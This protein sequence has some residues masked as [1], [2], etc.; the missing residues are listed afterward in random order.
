MLTQTKSLTWLVELASES[1]AKLL[2]NP[3][4]NSLSRASSIEELGWIHQLYF[5]SS[6]FTAATAIRYGKCDNPLFRNAFARHAAEEVEHPEQLANWMREYGLISAGETATSVKPNLPTLAL[7]AYFVRS[8]IREPLAHQII[9]L[10]LMT[11]SIAV[12]FYNRVN[13]K[14]A[15]LGLT[16]KGYWLVHQEADTEHQLLGL[17]LIPQ[18]SFDSALGKDY[19]RTIWE[20]T[21]LWQQV[22]YSWHELILISNQPYSLN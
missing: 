21:S 13:P 11:E 7:G 1:R 3:F 20:L 12:D 10:N 15:Q 8:V 14:L 18:C 4:Y 5:L 19:A 2:E 16:P 22:F 6:D 17:D 9:T